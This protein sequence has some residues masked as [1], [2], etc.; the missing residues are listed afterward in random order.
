MVLNRAYRNRD[1]LTVL[2]NVFYS[3]SGPITIFDS[4][5]EQKDRKTK[6]E[7][8][9]G[10]GERGRGAGHTYTQWGIRRE[11]EE[12]THTGWNAQREGV[13]A[14]RHTNTQRDIQRCE[15]CGWVG[16]R[17]THIHIKR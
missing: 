3:A 4:K 11:G 12:E 16:A 8:L 14:P 15:A 13:G 2:F 9:G 5:C 7:R 6:R 17:E 1:F 10:G